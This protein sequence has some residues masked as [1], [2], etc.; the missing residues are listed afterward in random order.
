MIQRCHNPNDKCHKDY[1]ARGIVVCDRWRASFAAFF[2]DMGPRPEGVSKGGRALYSIERKDNAAGYGPVN[3][4][5]ATQKEQAKNRRP[6]TGVRIGR[7]GKLGAIALAAAELGVTKS[8]IRYRLQQ[9]LTLEQAIAKPKDKRGRP[10]KA[11]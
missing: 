11:A 6:Y 8:A 9:G 4:V 2:E 3:C 5:W 10:R 7:P 1:G